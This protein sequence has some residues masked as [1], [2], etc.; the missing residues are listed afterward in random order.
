MF[1]GLIARR[2]V[3]ALAVCALA[4]LCGA[5]ALAIN[6]VVD[7]R[8]DT[9]GFFNAA[10][11]NGQK[12]RQTVE[13]AAAFF[14]NLITDSLLAIPFQSPNPPNGNWPVWR[15]VITHPGTGQA[16]YAISSAANSAVDGLTSS[17]G[18]ANEFRD[19][20]VPASE[21]RVYVGSTSLGGDSGLGGTGYSSYGDPPFNE[22]VAKRGKGP[23]EY[24]AWGGYAIFDSVATTNWHYDYATAVPAG[25]MDLYSV[26][27]HEIGHTLGLNGSNS[28]WN[29]K[30]VGAEWR[31]P[32]A[33]AAWKAEDPSASPSATGIP[34]VDA[35]NHHWLNN[36]PGQPFNP[37]VRSYILG[38]HILQEAAMDPSI[39]VGTRK[40]FTNVD[41]YAL[42]DIGWS[43]PQSAFDLSTLEADFNADTVVNGTDVGLWKTAFTAPSSGGDADGDG[44]SDGADLLIWQKQL[45]MSTATA[46]SLSTLAAVP[47][48]S[49]AILAGLALAALSRRRR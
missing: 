22:L 21:W 25:K 20:Q 6:I 39:T 31:G 23:G 30:Q 37:A 41:T 8:Y 14:S 12:A 26:A 24:S 49:A 32:L 1:R 33:F 19:I 38:T 34:T 16:G 17:Q 48:P 7:Y 36:Q 18:A 27:L 42:R 29:S 11:P 15:Q 47:E 35:S 9:S 13:H 28:T 10:T 44:D 3:V 5:S 43:I 45:G 40:L 2:V 46:A 4:A